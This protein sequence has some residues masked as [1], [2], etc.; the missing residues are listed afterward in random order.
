MVIICEIYRHIFFWFSEELTFEM[1]QATYKH[2]SQNPMKKNNMN[3]MW[4]TSH[5]A[6]LELQHSDST[7]Q[8]WLTLTELSFGSGFSSSFR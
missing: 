3:I 8:E 6:K 1:N 2:H 7:Q 5:A 4:A